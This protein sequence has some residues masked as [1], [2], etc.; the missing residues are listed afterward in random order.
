[1]LKAYTFIRYDPYPDS[2][3]VINTVYPF[4]HARDY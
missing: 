4:Q 3:S 1:M 2:S